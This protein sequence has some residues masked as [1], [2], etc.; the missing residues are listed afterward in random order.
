MTVGPVKTRSYW[1]VVIH[2]PQFKTM[3]VNSP[4]YGDTGA[5]LLFPSITLALEHVQRVE[6]Q[7]SPPLAE[8]I[9]V[10]ETTL[11]WISE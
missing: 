7:D 8:H 5:P 1:F 2:E 6:W 9:S 3:C 4:I 10:V 11:S